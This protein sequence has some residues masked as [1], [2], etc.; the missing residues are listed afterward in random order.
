MIDIKTKALA[1]IESLTA[2]GF[3]VDSKLVESCYE[4]AHVALGNCKNP[5]KDW[6]KE[7]DDMYERLI[8]TKK[9]EE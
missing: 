5:H 1:V 6:V 2:G 7:L 3:K 9:E 4:Y 8:T